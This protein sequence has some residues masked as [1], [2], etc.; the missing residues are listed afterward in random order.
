MTALDETYTLSNGVE[1][2]KLGLGT[3]FIDDDKAAEAV[4]AAVGIGYRNIDTAQAYGNEHGVGDGVRSCGE[5]RDELFVSTKLA[6]EIKDYDQAIA[7]IDGSLTTLGLDHV[8]LVLIHSPQ[9]WDDFRG[10]DYAQGNREAWRALEDA[11]RA[12]KIRSIGVSNFQRHDLENIL[13]G[14]S[15]VPHVNQLLVHAGNTPSDLLAYCQSKQILVEA[16]SP[17]A[18]G[19]ILT[20]A[21]VQAMAQKY[22]VSVPQLCIRY[23]L[24]LGTVSLPKTA[25]PEHMRSNAEVDFEISGADMDVLR[26][27]RGVDY[28]EHSAFPVYGGK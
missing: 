1:I 12:G 8:D 4:R 7:A 13:Q 6:A 26:D 5:P 25:N 23:T 22:G 21:E 18:H 19:A 24:Q 15:V 10:G 17:I 11:H 3:W 27:L 2:P 9:P 16:Y 20:N 14:A 28:G